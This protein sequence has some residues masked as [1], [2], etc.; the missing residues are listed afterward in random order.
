MTL[1]PL[2]SVVLEIENQEKEN[3]GKP[4][5]GDEPKAN[6]K[7]LP[8]DPEPTNH[9]EEDVAD[10][11]DAAQETKDPE[12]EEEEETSPT[13]PGGWKRIKRERK[14]LKAQLEETKRERQELAERLARMEGRF[15][16]N[17][18]QTQNQQ[19]QQVTQAQPNLEPNRD[20]DPDGWAQ[21][22]IQQQD[23]ENRNLKSTLDQI[24]MRAQ[25]AAAKEELSYYEDDYT[26][27]N[28]DY[29]NAR[30]FLLDNLMQQQKSKQPYATMATVKQAAE[31]ELLKLAAFGENTGL[32]PAETIDLL[33]SKR[34][35]TPNKKGNREVELPPSGSPNLDK[36]R[37]NK[38]KSSN[39]L[40]VSGQES[41]TPSSQQVYEMTLAEQA[42]HINKNWETEFGQ[43][44]R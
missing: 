25:I 23:A 16:Q 5:V 44:K 42:K 40:G 15:E 8:E 19:T 18:I 34:G 43:R 12:P 10:E 11:A 14:E 39:M 1:S 33:A 2:E 38:A 17:N 29:R 30:K 41:T 13:E 7:A 3:K 37:Q 27:K 4:I 6:S 21:W 31:L 26:A 9:E 35:Y 32:N 24:Q 20:Y 28:G 36:I 22:K